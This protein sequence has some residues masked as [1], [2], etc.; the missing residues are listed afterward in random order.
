MSL[1]RLMFTQPPALSLDD[2]SSPF[3]DESS[4]FYFFFL[5]I[6]CPRRTAYG[7]LVP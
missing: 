5:L 7:I 1:A 6:F 3:Q 2:E 4:E